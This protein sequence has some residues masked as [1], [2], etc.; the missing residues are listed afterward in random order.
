MIE[1]ASCLFACLPAP[2]VLHLQCKHSYLVFRTQLPPL[3]CMD[4]TSTVLKVQGRSDDPTPIDQS[5]VSCP[6]NIAQTHSHSPT[7][8]EARLFVFRSSTIPSDY[9][10]LHPPPIVQML[11]MLQ[12]SVDTVRT[13]SS[14]SNAKRKKNGRRRRVPAETKER[15]ARQDRLTGF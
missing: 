8:L 11:S 6:P 12:Y 9:R 14:T 5:L 7:A 4:Y 2:P 15:V 13:Q 10:L 3:L 1:N